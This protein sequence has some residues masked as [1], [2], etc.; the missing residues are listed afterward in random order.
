MGI[1]KAYAVSQNVNN[2]Q[3]LIFVEVS[4]VVCIPENPILT[5]VTEVNIMDI[6]VF[7][8]TF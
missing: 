1:N 6:Q 5:E 2:K 8:Q 4:F 7:K 3:L